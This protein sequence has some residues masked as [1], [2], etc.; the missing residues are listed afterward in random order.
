M[1]DI[2]ADPVYVDDPEVADYITALGKRLMAVADV[3]RKDVTYFV[4]RDDSINAFA[5]VGGHI[6]MHT[7]LFMLSQNE[8]ELAGVMAHEIAHI[9]QKHQA[10]SIAGAS[11]AS[12]ASLAAL[13]VA[14]LASRASSNSGGQVAEAAVT[15]ATA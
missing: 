12:W 1:R 9:L 14:V 15:A 5:L 3:P 8:S 6:G 10:R 13:A 4:L 11:R 7:G 2:R